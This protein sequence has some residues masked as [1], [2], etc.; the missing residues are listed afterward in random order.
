MDGDIVAAVWMVE[1]SLSAIALRGVTKAYDGHV[2]VRDVS[3][4]IPQGSVFGL[5]GPNGAGKTTTLRMVM[6]ILAPDSGVVEILGA[7]PGQAARDRIGYMPEERG[8]YPRMALGEQLLFLAEVKGTRRKEAARRLPAWLE[9]MGLAAWANKKTNELSKGMQQKAQFVAAVLHDPEILILDEPLSGLDPIGADMMRDL[10]VEL[11]RQGKTL[12]IS[13]H[14]MET[15]ER[16]CDR[17]ALINKGEKVLDGEVAAIKARRGRDTIVLAY[18]GDGAFLSTLP[19]VRSVRDFGRY[20]E[21]RMADGADPNAILRAAAAR[22]SV[23]RFEVAEPSL[24][25]IFVETVG[26]SDNQRQGGER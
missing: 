21:M 22:L 25:D 7:P 14:Q 8:L 18:D 4:E 23:R 15:V 16:I 10:L 20:V 3:L 17:V 9:R 6:N 13:S 12:V 5:L 26:G 1:V 24:H 19:G 11:S 2:A